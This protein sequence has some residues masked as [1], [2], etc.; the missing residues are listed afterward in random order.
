MED[1][2]VKYLKKWVEVS[3]EV[4]KGKKVVVFFL[5]KILV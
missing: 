2:I 4:L 3:L 5:G 1:I